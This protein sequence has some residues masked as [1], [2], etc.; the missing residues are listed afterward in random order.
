MASRGF[1]AVLVISAVVGVVASL[2]AWLFLEFVHGAQRWVFADLPD[3]LGFGSTPLWW[4][5]PVMALAGLLAALAIERL[6]GEGG[7]RPSRGLD[8]EPTR[9]AMLPGVA[10]AAL[11]SIGGGLVLGPEAPLIAIGGGLGFLA[12]HL[13][14]R[15]A[16]ED[17][18]TLIAAAGTF[19]AISFLFGSPLIAAV[20]LV[21]A[22]AP[23]K[24]RLPL[25]LLP[26]LLAA[27]IGSLVSL[28][29]GSWTGVDRD[30]I[31]FTLL[32]LPELDRPDL[33][34]FLW[35]V[36]LAAAVALVAVMIFRV[37]QRAE[38]VVERRR[39]VTLPA[40]GL[41]VAGLAIAFSELTDKSVDQVLYSGQTT[42]GPLVSEAGSWSLGALA[43]V[44]AC[45]GLAYALSLAGFRGGPVFPALF[46]GA[47]AGVMAAHLPGLELTAA[48]SVCIGAAVTAVLWLPL[49]GVV[50][51]ALLTSSAGLG[52]TPLIILGVVVAYLVALAVAPP[53][54]QPAP[55]AQPA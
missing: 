25:L 54:E 8:P 7:H 16:P 47:A 12:V 38:P 4:Y 36:P 33:V 22:A 45:K 14:R 48:V 52:T 51:A 20:L 23:G 31:S 53:P 43:L 11:A 24:E 1:V 39:L 46:L 30:D 37:A 50:L 44:I 34:D 41:V 35:T 5:L 55:A 3:A 15:D 27:G 49:S 21:E 6:P 28:G 10:L 13:L 42:I 17:L 40:I 32:Q 2:V 26:G 29:M 18:G 9:P 19:A